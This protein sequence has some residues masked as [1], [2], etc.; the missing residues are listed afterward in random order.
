MWGGSGFCNQ[1]ELL[2]ESVP[3]SNG[4]WITF[5]FEF[6]P[7]QNH[8]YFTIEA[9]YKTPIL[10]PY[11]GHILVD[12][13]SNIMRIACPGEEIAVVEEEPEPVKEKVVPPHKR[14]KKPEVKAEPPVVAN[15]ESQEKPEPKIMMD[16]DRKKIKKGQTLTIKNL[17]FGA[18]KSDITSR[19]YAVLNEIFLFLANNDDIV[20]EIGGHTNGLCEQEFCDELSTDRAKK[21]AQ[22]LNSR[23]I[24]ASRLQFKGYGK[25]KQI[26]SN[27]T[28]LGRQKNQRVEIKIL[29]LES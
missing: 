23:G 25:R 11:N 8:R 22:Y 9:F 29:E 14:R 21:V 27:N 12:N 7:T 20:I 1:R 15:V 18:D 24:E 19:S 28:A 2:A 5:E 17:Y 13:A 6:R 3:I 16:L 10:F 26:A 4:E